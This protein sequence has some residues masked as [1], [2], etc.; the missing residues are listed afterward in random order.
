MDQH[1]RD[2]AFKNASKKYCCDRPR[3]VFCKSLRIDRWLW[4]VF[5]SFFSRGFFRQCLAAAITTRSITK[6]KDAELWL[7]LPNSPCSSLAAMSPA[8][9][10]AAIYVP[11]FTLQ[12]IGRCE[13]ELRT[14]PLAIIDGPPPTYQ[15]VA[16]NRLADILG[17]ARIMKKNTVTQ[18]AHVTIRTR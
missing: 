16:L 11:N 17:G 12:A 7:S 10:F 3:I 13:P 18:F 5:E 9:L 14:R 15:V 4:S 8:A 6:R 2:D 1:S